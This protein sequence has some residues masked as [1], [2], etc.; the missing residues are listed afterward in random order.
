[1]FVAL[2][3]CCKLCFTEIFRS[4]LRNFCKASRTSALPPSAVNNAHAWDGAGP[5]AGAA[6]EFANI[7]GVGAER[8]GEARGPLDELRDAAPK[9][10]AA[11]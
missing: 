10:A 11:A 5:S 6:G 4:G 3:G 1:M 7:R 2:D 8:F 9:D